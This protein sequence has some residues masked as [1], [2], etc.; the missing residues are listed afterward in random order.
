MGAYVHRRFVAAVAVLTVIGAL[1]AA[2]AHA[3]PFYVSGFTYELTGPAWFTEVIL[4]GAPPLDAGDFIDVDVPGLGV[5]ATLLPGETFLFAPVMTPIFSLI[6]IDSLV[7]A[8]DPTSFPTFLDWTGAATALTMTPIP[9]DAVPEP[10]VAA[11]IGVAIT[12]ALRRRATRA[13]RMA[14][15]RP[16]A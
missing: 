6:G 2:P 10:G 5:I 13:R 15:D 4:P 3:A 16:S 1:S 7:D 12:M 14:S 8:N 11:M 9:R